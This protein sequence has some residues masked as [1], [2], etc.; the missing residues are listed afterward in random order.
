[1]RYKIPVIDGIDGG[2]PDE[3]IRICLLY[4]DGSN[5]YYHFSATKAEHEAALRKWQRNY[6]LELDQRSEGPG[7]LITEYYIATEKRSEPA[8]DEDG[9]LF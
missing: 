5:P 8:P 9:P 2:E 1:M 4:T 3:A 7:E 6:I